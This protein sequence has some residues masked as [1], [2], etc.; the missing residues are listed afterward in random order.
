MAA[1]GAEGQEANCRW[2]Q[3]QGQ[4]E[5]THSAFIPILLPAEL[6]RS[7]TKTKE[8]E[9]VSQDSQG[10]EVWLKADWG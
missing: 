5:P 2:S 3:S 7:N 10:G 8:E 4:A 6:Y 1:G 9:G